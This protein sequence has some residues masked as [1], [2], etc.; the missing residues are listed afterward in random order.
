MGG[1]GD[2]AERDVLS[3]EGTPVARSQIMDGRLLYKASLSQQSE[4]GLDPDRYMN[5]RDHSNLGGENENG[6]D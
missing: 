2:L 1:I 6:S 4:A 5:V 3:A